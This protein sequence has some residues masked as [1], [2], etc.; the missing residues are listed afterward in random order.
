M[1][2]AVSTQIVSAL[3]HASFDGFASVSEIGP[4]GM[5]SLRAKADVPGLAA[6]MT[7]VLMAYRS[8]RSSAFAILKSIL[9]ATPSKT[10]TSSI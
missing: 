5:I 2:D 8:V 9:M 7:L 4:V 1:S 3:G 10:A 6:A